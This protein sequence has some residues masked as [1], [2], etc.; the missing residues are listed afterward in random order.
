M[1]LFFIL[2]YGE[3]SEKSTTGHKNY[4]HATNIQKTRM[5]QT[6]GYGRGGTLSRLLQGR[7]NK[8]SL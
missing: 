5:G 1:Y 2:R 3:K 8:K 4:L 6:F 7:W